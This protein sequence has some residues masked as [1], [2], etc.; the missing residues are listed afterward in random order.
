MRTIT[1]V[2][3]SF[4]AFSCSDDDRQPTLKP[5]SLFKL[6][7]GTSTFS[8]FADAL[9]ITG[10]DATLDGSE[11]FTVFVPNDD[12]FYLVLGGLTVEEFDTAN[13]G[14]LDDIVKM[15]IVSSEVLS[16]DLTDGQAVTTLGGQTITVN[17]ED[18][19]FYPEYDNDLGVIEQTSIFVND[20]RVFARDGKCANGII[21]TVNAVIMPIGG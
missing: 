2:A 13:P 3:I 18:N 15:H 11:D 8:S 1:L 20:A 16:K 17:L 21:H 6:I 7:D 19:P 14:V 10:L 9:K 5:T 4:L 12:A